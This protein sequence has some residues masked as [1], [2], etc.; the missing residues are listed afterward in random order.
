MDHET[1]DENYNELLA[2]LECLEQVEVKPR[3]TI[4]EL[5]TIHVAAFLLRKP[6]HYVPP[7]PIVSTGEF[8]QETYR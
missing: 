8:E 3:P 6:N 1:N 7:I 2:L 4:I 5:I